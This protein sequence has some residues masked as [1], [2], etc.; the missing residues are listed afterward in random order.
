MILAAWTIGFT[1]WSP[2]VVVPLAGVAVFGMLRLLGPELAAKSEGVRRLLGGLRAVAVGLVVLFLTEPVVTVHSR[3]K[4][5]PELLVMM[6]ASPSMAVKDRGVPLHVRLGEA[7]ALGLAPGE[8]VDTS[9]SEAATALRAL[10][11]DIPAIQAA[12]SG[13]ESRRSDA[14]VRERVETHIK[15]I[16]E[17]RSPLAGHAPINTGLGELLERLRSIDEAL[18]VRADSGTADLGDS[19]PSRGLEQRVTE[20]LHQCHEV[21]AGMDAALLSGLNSDNPVLAGV[22]KLNEMTRYE[23]ARHLLRESLLP[24]IADKAAPRFVRLNRSL[25]PVDIAAAPG[26]TGAPEYEGL[27]NFETALQAVARGGGN[28][29]LAGVLLLT[30]GRQTAGGDPAPA[31]RSLRARGVRVGAV[32]V[33][34]A[35]TPRDAA[36]GGIL[37]SREVFRGEVARMDVRYRITGFPAGVSWNLIVS[38][39]GEEIERRN[40]G[41]STGWQ[42]ERFEFP[43]EK[44]G[45]LSVQARLQRD[46]ESSGH[47]SGTRGVLREYW[48]GVGGSRVADLAN[49]KGYPDKPT[50]TD[51]IEA[52]QTPKSW[53]DNY[54]QRLRAYLSPPVTGTYTFWITSDDQGELWLGTG[55]SSKDKTLIARVKSHA[56]T[57]DWGKFPGQKSEPVHLKKGRLYYIEARHKEG[58]GGDHLA[59]GWQLPDSTVE[60]PIPAGR[61][62]PY[63]EKIES[64]G[65]LGLSEDPLAEATLDNNQANVVVAVNEDPLRVLLVDAYPRWDSRYLVTLLE[66]DRRVEVE[67][68][69]RTMRIARGETT[70]LPSTQEAFDTYDIVILG[71]LQPS[72]LTPD[73]QQRLADFVGKR[74]GFLVLLAGPRALPQHYGIGRLGDVM[75]VKIRAG[76]SAANEANPTPRTLALAEGASGHT[77][78]SV[79]HDQSLNRKLWAALPPLTWVCDRVSAKAGAEVLLRTDD[80]QRIPVAVMSRYDMGRVFYMGTDETWRWRDRLGDRIHQTFWL[81]VFRWGLGARLRGED[82]RLQMSVDRS[83]LRPDEPLEV[84][85]RASLSD[86]T[87]VKT[88]PVIRIEKADQDESSAQTLRDEEMELLEGSSGIWTQEVLD[89]PEGRWR[90]TVTSSHPELKELSE[91]RLVTVRREA[92]RETAEVEA[93]PGALKRI[94]QAGGHRSGDII[95]AESIVTSLLE[96]L[97][98][99]PQPVQR[100]YSLWNNYFALLL[101]VGVLMTEWVLRKRHGLP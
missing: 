48:S 6:D 41:V 49:H 75:P 56:G 64:G 9:A 51:I 81:Q 61:L 29:S 80:A 11:T 69:Y 87:P 50:G 52:F 79:L 68:R 7:I 74:G 57:D 25:T 19:D 40:V 62:I 15:T 95:E 91:V 24:V 58:H 4:R 10:R 65:A 76:A 39:D 88:A 53:G 31:L 99:R 16:A 82:P 37:G 38:V 94:T 54:G 14:E 13:G 77:V 70:L 83:L 12:L 2:L 100:T 30:D 22:M 101:V 66:R 72:E 23:R 60:R 55:L 67:R 3:E 5:L 93:D 8:Q 59:A 21:Q 86:G 90:L 34:R 89:L 45:L 17:C 18:A 43:A 1:G 28:D 98:I 36:I 35:D 96:S 73:D 71:D 63:T 97:E 78:T 44:S 20:L 32:M 92:M 42:T 47:A 84:R 26:E 85:A 46:H 27:T 33:G